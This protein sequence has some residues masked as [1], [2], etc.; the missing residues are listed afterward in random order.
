MRRSGIEGALA[1]VAV[2]ALVASTCGGGPSTPGPTRTAPV[3]TDPSETP[4]LLTEI[5][6]RG[7]IRVAT[8]PR[9][10]PQSSLNRETGEWEGFDVDVARE[11]ADRLDVD[12]EIQD[13][14][15]TVVSGGGWN[16]Q[17]DMSVGSMPV[18]DE[19][20]EVFSFSPAYYYTPAAVVVHIDNTSVRNVA[21]DLD[22]KT[23]CVRGSTT[24]E[25]YL[26]GN[27]RLVESAP[28]FEFVV[29]DPKI[30]TSTT[31]GAVL[32]ALALG[33]GLECDAAIVGRP[34]VQKYLSEHGTNLKVVG[35]ALYHEPL[36]IAF[37]RSSGFDDASLVRAIGRIVEAM[38]ADGTL[39][40]LSVKWYGVDLTTTSSG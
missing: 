27:L 10:A 19:G 5:R 8:D 29:D 14:D 33:D 12:L 36:A 30:K 35:E 6:A 25:S 18:T 24:Y 20:S 4:D 13:R 22:G 39:S 17:W 31:D 9:Y 21:T 32:N 3:A 26:L 7:L 16:D 28:E 15:W 2:F 40:E 38:H 11:I 1:L 23:I 34:T 37:D